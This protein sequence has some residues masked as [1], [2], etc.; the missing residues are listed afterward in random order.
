VL[1]ALP[2]QSLHATNGFLDVA[3]GGFGFNE[4]ISAANLLKCKCSE[5]EMLQICL[6]V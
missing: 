3:N 2:Q 1:D 6:S 4:F 5:N